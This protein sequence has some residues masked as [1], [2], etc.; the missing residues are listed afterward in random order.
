M[1]VQIN[2]PDEEKIGSKCMR[3]DVDYKCSLLVRKQEEVLV[4]GADLLVSLC[5]CKI[6]L[7]D[8]LTEYEGGLAAFQFLPLRKI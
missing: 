1:E 4:T 7:R 5:I 2:W 3:P 6:V 8:R